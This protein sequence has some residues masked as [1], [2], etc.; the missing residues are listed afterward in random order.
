MQAYI[1]LADALLDGMGFDAK[2]GA[3]H[4]AMK[5]DSEKISAKREPRTNRQ[6]K[7]SAS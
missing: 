5:N 1:E 7:R 2:T 6:T 3:F 4:G